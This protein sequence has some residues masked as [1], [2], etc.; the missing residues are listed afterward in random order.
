MANKNE[1]K[2]INLMDVNEDNF[3][4]SLKNVN[5]YGEDIVKLAAEKADEKEKER[6]VREFNEIKDKATYLNLSLV[7]RSKYS[8]ET[9]NIMAAAR[10]ESKELLER[11]TKGELTATQYDKELQSIIDKHVKK[12]EEVG[13]E[14]RSDLEELRKAFPNNWSYNWDNPY[15]RLNRAIEN[16]K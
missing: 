5:R 14:L 11:V 7:A 15:Q 6:M 12:V 10:N 9:N 3:S 13:K 1:K 8:K 16:N 4:E 2:T